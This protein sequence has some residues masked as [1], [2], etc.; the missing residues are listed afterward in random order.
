MKLPSR[1]M[2]VHPAPRSASVALTNPPKSQT[3]CGV[4]ANRAETSAK[5]AS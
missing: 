2:D 3:R 5:V 4:V 1:K